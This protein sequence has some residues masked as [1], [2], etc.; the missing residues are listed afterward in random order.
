MQTP[1]SIN[2]Q[3]G[4]KGI[5]AL[6]IHSRKL[7]SRQARSGALGDDFSKSFG[8]AFGHGGHLITAATEGPSG[9]GCAIAALAAACARLDNGAELT[10]K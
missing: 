1:P 10:P 5:N 4:W 9:C 3:L 2:R 6:D 8:V 7:S